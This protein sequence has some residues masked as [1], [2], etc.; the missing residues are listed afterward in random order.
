VDECKPLPT[1]TAVA[2][3]CTPIYFNSPFARTPSTPSTATAAGAAAPRR[4]QHELSV[5]RVDARQL[6]V[7][8]RQLEQLPSLEGHLGTTRQFQRLCVERPSD[9]STLNSLIDYIPSVL[10]STSWTPALVGTVLSMLLS[11]SWTPALTGTFLTTTTRPTLNGRRTTVGACHRG[12]RR[13]EEEERGY[14]LIQR[15]G[16]H[17]R[18]HARRC[19]RP[20]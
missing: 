20:S 6:R 5:Q 13:G 11:T 9:Y 16:H 14:M 12:S 15:P 19:E 8:R 3:P 4:V 2:N 7:P 17:A 1:A 10:L 18:G